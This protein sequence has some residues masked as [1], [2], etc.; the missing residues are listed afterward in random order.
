MIKKN[1]CEIWNDTTGMV[2]K[3][4]PI[5]DTDTTAMTIKGMP[6]VKWYNSDASEVAAHVIWSN[7]DDSEMTAHAIWNSSDSKSFIW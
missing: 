5:V 2:W 7:T 1:G 4:L 6:N 3:W